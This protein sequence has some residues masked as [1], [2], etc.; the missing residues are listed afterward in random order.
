VIYIP[1]QLRIQSF[2]GKQG[3]IGN[4]KYIAW[5]SKN[6]Y[7]KSVID[8]FL[9]HFSLIVLNLIKFIIKAHKSIFEIASTTIIV[10]LKG[11]WSKTEEG[12]TSI[13][14]LSIQLWC[15]KTYIKGLYRRL[16][17]EKQFPVDPREWSVILISPYLAVTTWI[18]QATKLE[19]CKQN[20]YANVFKTI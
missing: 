14:N 6:R 2:R 4:A 1:V 9:R 16:K 11:S 10:L 20:F 15:F 13:R 19:V 3:I 17:A 18:N 12:G 7:N 8:D 5:F